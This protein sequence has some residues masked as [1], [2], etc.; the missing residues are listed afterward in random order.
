MHAA[1]STCWL[2]E[3]QQHVQALIQ[4]IVLLVGAHEQYLNPKGKIKKACASRD[5]IYLM[6]LVFAHSVK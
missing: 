4:D 2:G 1:D 6:S 3:H 5:I